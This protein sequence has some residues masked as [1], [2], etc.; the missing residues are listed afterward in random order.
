MANHARVVA[1]TVAM[2]IAVAC[3]R[4]LPLQLESAV[5]SITGQGLT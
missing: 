4:P 3:N 1:T 5:T 2:L